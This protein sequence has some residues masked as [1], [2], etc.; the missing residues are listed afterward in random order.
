[1]RRRVAIARILLKRPEL[2]LLDEPF[3]ALDPGGREWLT[4]VIREF[5]EGG[6]TLL[7]ATHLPQVARAVA[8]HALIL[9][10]GKVAFCGLVRDLPAELAFE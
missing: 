8:E 2:V 3:T 6:T 5:R 1:M 10:S 7:M 4:G 9:D